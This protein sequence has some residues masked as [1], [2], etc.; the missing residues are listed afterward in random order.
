MKPIARSIS[1]WSPNKE[2]QFKC[3]NC[4]QSFAFYRKKEK[5]CHNCG[6][7]VDWEN[8]PIRL[9]ESFISNSIEEEKELIQKINQIIDAI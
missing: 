9:K 2:I 5:Y 4:G 8:I 6:T 1:D 3:R 7:K